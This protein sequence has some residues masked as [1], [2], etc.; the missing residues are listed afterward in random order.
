[1]TEGT[2][3]LSLDS[4]PDSQS[5]PVGKTPC[6]RHLSPGDILVPTRWL[7]H[8]IPAI[9]EGQ[10]GRGSVA[11]SEPAIDMERPDLLLLDS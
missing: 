11:S 2:I 5:L 8:D 10:V 4:T 1:M 9:K 3:S 6:F 7:K